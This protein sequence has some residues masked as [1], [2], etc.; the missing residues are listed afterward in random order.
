MSKPITTVALMTL[1]E[2]GKFRLDDKVS[3]YIPE[4]AETLV[5]TPGEEGFTL[6]PQEN[7]MTIRN[8]LTHTSGLTYGWEQGSYVDSIYYASGVVNWDAPIGEE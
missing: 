4:F 7:E 5:Y 6:E 3:E 2:D 8:L 1:F